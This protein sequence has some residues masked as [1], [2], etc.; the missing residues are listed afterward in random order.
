MSNSV[1]AILSF[2]TFFISQALMDKTALHH[3]RART[4]TSSVILGHW[5]KVSLGKN[6]TLIPNSVF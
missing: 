1:G 6:C 3:N 2:R 5:Q 4:L